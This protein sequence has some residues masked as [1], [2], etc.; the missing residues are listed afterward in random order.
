MCVW[1][2]GE[3]T[4][5]TDLTKLGLSDM[6]CVNPSDSLCGLR[7]SGLDCQIDTHTHHLYLQMQPQACHSV[8]VWMGS[9]AA[10]EA[11]H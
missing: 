9:V 7:Q 6:S 3:F 1:G 10:S 11:L 2:G 4:N 5:F 8:K